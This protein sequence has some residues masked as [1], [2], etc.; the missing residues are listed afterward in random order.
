[1]FPLGLFAFFFPRSTASNGWSVLF[2]VFVRYLA[3]AVVYFRARSRSTVAIMLAILM[4][5]LVCNVTGCRRM[6]NTH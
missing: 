4:L 5:A 2:G 3:H 6:I 1:M